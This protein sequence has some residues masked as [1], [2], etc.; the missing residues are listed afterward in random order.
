MVA[1]LMVAIL[2]TVAVDV[3]NDCVTF[4]YGPAGS[5]PYEVFAV[6]AVV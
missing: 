3:W 4:V 6:S 5:S 2:F 1:W